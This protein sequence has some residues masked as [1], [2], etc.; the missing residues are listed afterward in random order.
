MAKSPNPKLSNE[1]TLYLGKSGSG[2]SQ[3]LKQN[4]A[5]P[6][7]GVRC[8]LWDCSHDHEKGTTYYNQKNAFIDAVSRAI[9]SGKGF[10]IG[11]DGDSSP[12]AF[13]WFAGVVW[14]VLDGG[15]ITYVII[16]E[17]ARCVETVGRAAP[18][19]RKLY[20][21][22]RKYGA[23]IHAVTQRPQEIPKT[24]YDQAERFVVG[25]QK[26]PNIRRF[27]ELLDKDPE[28]IKILKPLEFWYLDESSGKDAE[29]LKLKYKG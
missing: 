4:A 3:A 23:R 29:F 2:K 12:D 7:H 17:L 16:E 9:K 14:A 27:A 20:N 13:E 28:D 21:E 26:G 10:R 18:N 19:L 11:W 6:S 15:K 24:V 5:I 1:H 25:M 8:L 22:G